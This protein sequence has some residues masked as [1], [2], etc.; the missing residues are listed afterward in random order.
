MKIQFVRNLIL[1]IVFALGMMGLAGC[2]AN[3]EAQAPAAPAPANP[4]VVAPTNPP[5]AEQAKPQV[6][7]PAAQGVMNTISEIGRWGKG[8]V[9]SI[10]YSPDGKTLAV[11]TALGLY[12]YD[13]T[14]WNERY[15]DTADEALYT[16]AFSSDGTMLAVGTSDGNIN[17]RQVS[18]GKLVR[19]MT[20]KDEDRHKGI[21]TAVAFSA[22]G[23]TLVSGS[24]DMTV[25]FW[26][27][28][29]GSLL[30]KVEDA[31]STRVNSVAFSPDN[32]TIAV[33]TDFPDNKVMVFKMGEKQ[34]TTSY[35]D[36]K[37]AVYDVSFSKD[38]SLLA[39]G[40]L[41][42]TIHL[43]KV[44]DGTTIKVFTTPRTGTPVP[45]PTIDPNLP[46]E[47]A[48][49]LQESQKMLSS[50]QLPFV[51]SVAFS[52]DGSLVAGG[53][54]DNVIRIWQASDG[55]LVKTLEGA[56]SLMFDVRFA[57]DGKNIAARSVDGFVRV[58]Q[59]SDGAITK[60]FDYGYSISSLAVSPDG[61]NLAVG[62]ETN[63]VPIKKVSDGS[64]VTDLSRHSNRITSVTYS[65]DGTKLADASV[66]GYA[67]LWDLSDT[68]RAKYVFTVLGPVLSVAIS[69]D[70]QLLAGGTGIN[71]IGLWN[72]SDGKTRATLK[73]HTA[74]VSAVAFS[75]DGTLL[76]SASDDT[77]VRLWYTQDGKQLKSLEGHTDIVTGVAFS[78][79][80]ELLAT[81]S[82]DNTIRL[83]KIP[84]GESFKVIQP[85]LSVRT[86]AFSKDG[87]ILAAA[88]S[89]GSVAIYKVNE[90]TDSPFVV[91][92]GHKQEVTSIVFLPDGK[93]VTGSRDGTIRFWAL[94]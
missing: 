75:P 18:D 28:S 50:T 69:P 87:N 66:D 27:V 36:H 23:Q 10:A 91:L 48:K 33:A 12:F 31:F 41:D 2:G 52:P 1:L 30:Q 42:G 51:F 20:T 82:L 14:S 86:I 89:D 37:N 81:S 39:S 56:K 73:G 80:G 5:V 43:Y 17:L 13:T 71:V 40:S 72:L 84:S 88:L 24:A 26:K 53:Y 68:S 29:D 67:R 94:K 90:N 57:P 62:G 9:Q 34:P 38:G 35:T 4:P 54:F 11:G 92:Q 93:I 3:E 83:W 58:W 63:D 74:G 22:D 7:A 55:A 32:V 44:S 8:R 70:N 16:M 76:A 60:S 85:L 46:E 61:N 65:S 79:N 49:L 21:V 64:L 47:Q 59:L 77:S 6:A 15:V 25:R 45:Q 78:P 19:S